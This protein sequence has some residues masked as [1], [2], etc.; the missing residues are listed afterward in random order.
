MRRATAAAW[1]A[2]CVAGVPLLWW[3]RAPLRDTEPVVLDDNGAVHSTVEPPP[4]MAEIHLDGFSVNL[5]NPR[6]EQPEIQVATTPPPPPAPPPP[7]PLGPA[8]ILLAIIGR[9][10][11]SPSAALYDPVADVIVIV[12]EGDRILGRSVA[13]ITG[14][15]VDLR[16]GEQLTRLVLV[17][18]VRP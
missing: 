18:E 1:L 3:A 15:A 11:E 6:R 14:T 2:V 4:R 17:D 10:S 13:G 5:W 12:R 8:P 16:A 9:A 7:V